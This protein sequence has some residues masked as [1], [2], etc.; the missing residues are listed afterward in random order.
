MMDLD[1]AFDI[2]DSHAHLDMADFDPD[3]DAVLQRAWTGGIR[4]I[5]CPAD[6]TMPESLAK[7]LRLCLS[8]PWVHA[9][10]GV[11]PHQASKLTE[12]HLGVMSDL[13][14]QGKIKAV[15][16]IGLDYHYHLSPPAKQRAA[17]RQQLALAEKLAL[18]VVIHSRSSGRDIIAAVEGEDFS[19]G[20]VLHCF[21]EDWETARRM[22][23]LGFHL[24]FSGILTYPSAA[25]LREIARK[26]PLDHVLLETD[27]PYL[28]PVPL[29]GNKKRNEP[30]FVLPTAHV[31]AELKNKSAEGIGQAVL[32]N[33]RVL[34][35]V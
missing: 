14:A 18:P 10:A 3:R 5:L 8:Y 35:N 32:Q 11:H 17:F 29:R 31:L 24:S 25:H 34:F 30:L 16:E 4:A 26:T 15:G 9:A 28:V 2:A 1:S 27:S 19:R 22:M 12:E 21:T 13:A 6:L 7:T 20:G 33:H 23:D